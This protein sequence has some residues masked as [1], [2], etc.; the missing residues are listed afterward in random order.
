MNKH[1]WLYCAVSYTIGLII[2]AGSVMVICEKVL[3]HSEAILK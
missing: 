3:L 1:L 2:G